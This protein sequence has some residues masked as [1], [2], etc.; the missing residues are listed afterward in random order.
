MTTPATCNVQESTT[1]GTLFVA[2]ELSEKTGRVPAGCGYCFGTSP[3]P[4][5]RD[6]S[7]GDHHSKPVFKTPS[8]PLDLQL[9][10]LSPSIIRS[11]THAGF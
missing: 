3:N 2:F 9:S 10:T 6:Q 11:S 7:A 5:E 8:T 1:A 4:S